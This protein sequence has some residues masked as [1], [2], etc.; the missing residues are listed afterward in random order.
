[1]N[2]SWIVLVVSFACFLMVSARGAAAGEE[3]KPVKISMFVEHDPWSVACVDDAKIAVQGGHGMGYGSLARDFP[4]G[5]TYRVSG[6]MGWS[7]VLT[8]GADGSKRLSDVQAGPRLASPP[9]CRIAEDGA[10][11]AAFG[12]IPEFHFRIPVDYGPWEIAG[13]YGKRAGYRYAD[14]PDGAWKAA[15]DGWAISF[16]VASRKLILAGDEGL[17]VGAVKV[18]DAGLSLPDKVLALPAPPE[19][20]QP[21]GF[22]SV[23]DPKTKAVDLQPAF[24]SPVTLEGANFDLAGGK[25]IIGVGKAGDLVLAAGVKADGAA[26][27]AFAQFIKG[28]GDDWAVSGK[29]TPLDPSSTFKGADVAVKLRKAGAADAA[30]TELKDAPPGAYLLTVTAKSPDAKAACETTLLVPVAGGAP[31][32]SIWLPAGRLAYDAREKI[33]VYV[34]LGG[35]AT[36]QKAELLATRDGRL[37]VSLCSVKES[38]LVGVAPLTFSPGEVT[39]LLK[40]DGKEAAERT[41]TILPADLPTNFI[42]MAYASILDEYQNADKLDS[43]GVKGFL[44]QSGVVFGVRGRANATARSLAR[45]SKWLPAIGPADRYAPPCGGFLEHLDRK[46]WKFYAQWGSAHQPYGYGISF[47]DHIVV[48]RLTASSAWA[49]M[50]G[51]QHPCFWGMNVFDEGGTSRGP[52]MWEDGTYVDYDA[53]AKKFGRPKPKYFGDD[54]D[55]ARAWIYDKQHQQDVVYRGIGGVLDEMNRLAGPGAFLYLGTQ[56]G[57]LNSM[58]VDA[59]HPPLSYGAITLSTMHWYSDYFYKSFILCG[60]EYHFMQPQFVSPKTA[61]A[62]TSPRPD[63]RQNADR[64]TPIEFAPLIWS[65]GDFYLTRHEASLAISRQV[66]GLAHFHWPDMLPQKYFDGDPDPEVKRFGDGFKEMHARLKTFGD[67]FRTIRRD[68]PSEVAVLY[69]LYDFAPNLYPTKTDDWHAYNQAYRACYTGYVAMISLLRAGVQA[70]WLCEEEIL[71]AD[72][73]TGRKVLIVPGIGAM[74]PALKQK[75]E[76]FIARGGTVFAD[77]G[78]TVE[79]KGAKTLPI[80]FA[81]LTD[82]SKT[83]NGNNLDTL[84]VPQVLPVIK[85][86]IAPLV[87]NVVEAG[88]P[89]LLITRQVNGAGVYYLGVNEQ[90]LPVEQLPE[91]NMYQRQ[92]YHLPIVTTLTLPGKGVAYDVLAGKQVAQAG[93][94]KVAVRLPPG[95]LCVFAVL[96]EAVGSVRLK[97]AGKVQ[98]G[99]AVPLKVEVLGASGNLLK[100][101]VPVQIDFMDAAAAGRAADVRQTLY[102]STDGGRW[103]GEFAAGL[104]DPDAITV[105][106]RELLSGKEASAQMKVTRGKGY[107]Q[108]GEGDVLVEN[109]KALQPEF[110]AKMKSVYLAV[111]EHTP[112][113]ALAPLVKVLQGRGVDVK[114]RRAS[115]MTVKTFDTAVGRGLARIDSEICWGAGQAYEVDRPVIAIGAAADNRLLNYVLWDRQWTTCGALGGFPGAGKSYVSFLWRPFSLVH[116]GVVAVAEDDAALQAAVKYLARA[117]KNANSK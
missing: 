24:K 67:F 57:N 13:A 19:D 75:I 111:G 97:V 28:G 43:L 8:I 5:H 14:L 96:P 116:N 106:V 3:A 79:L 100:A 94:A 54:N 30:R 101:A 85:K 86:E 76:A 29:A 18:D 34:W 92:K 109:G 31:A 115:Q 83:A 37:P 90:V 98:A 56:N 45:A 110:F 112:E 81:S 63:I 42:I 16:R 44:E 104:F 66:D 11:D 25:T 10:F 53:F 9:N 71:S 26:V 59:G 84:F 93:G 82:N 47:T 107:A 1:M 68:R 89:D 48:D 73:L 74:M 21:L 51:R 49:S 99:K 114:V 70:G 117:A 12:T 77:M 61:A 15:G 72:G 60:N 102:R 33:D 2:M 55:A 20:Q 27:E 80:D 7:C 39:L 91:L 52:R 50:A 65:D 4:P 35:H 36:P 62:A 108:P 103:T 38:G 17:P 22:V 69:S 105:R 58:A 88:S 64:H 23:F 6:H 95:D 87:Q 78:T 113:A 40:V 41:I 32:V 46:G